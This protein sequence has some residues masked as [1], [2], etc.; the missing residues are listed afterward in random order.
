MRQKGQ[1]TRTKEKAVRN[2]LLFKW[3]NL[4][5]IKT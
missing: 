1:G 2:I 4:T 3:K 5:M